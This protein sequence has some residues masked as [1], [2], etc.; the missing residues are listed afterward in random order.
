M[1]NFAALLIFAREHFIA[2]IDSA[3]DIVA[4]R[5]IEGIFR[6]RSR[7]YFRK[8]RCIRIIYQDGW[9]GNVLGEPLQ[10]FPVKLRIFHKKRSDG[11][12]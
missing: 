11:L 7:P 3:P 1:P 5:N 8:A 10:R 6:V 9:I 4:Q 12:P 2:D